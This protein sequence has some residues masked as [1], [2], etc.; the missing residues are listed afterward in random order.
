M[1]SLFANPVT[2]LWFEYILIPHQ[3]KVHKNRVVYCSLATSQWWWLSGSEFVIL[4][5]SCLLSTEPADGDPSQYK[6]AGLY[7]IMW[8]ILNLI[9]VNTKHTHSLYHTQF[10]II[11]L[12]PSWLFSQLFWKVML[13]TKAENLKKKAKQSQSTCSTKPSLSFFTATFS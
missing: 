11:H 7:L 10:Y 6:Q 5:E 8:Q 12:L 4:S 3:W 2:C 13:T 1:W 9:V